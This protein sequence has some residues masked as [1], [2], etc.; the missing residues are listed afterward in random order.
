MKN[1]PKKESPEKIVF[2]TE[3]LEILDKYKWII[4]SLFTVAAF[5][6]SPAKEFIYHKIWAEAGVLAITA[7]SNS[8]RTQDEIKLYLTLLPN[9]PVGLSEG[10]ATV[11]LSNN[12]LRL[13]N[14]SKIFSTP[15]TLAPALLMD[16]KPLLL[17]AIEPGDAE[18]TV[19]VKT[20]L[21]YP[22]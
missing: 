13:V 16:G 3:T 1:K 21:D 22:Q 12:N 5:F 11:T 17:S 19:E 8:V 7:D 14:Q 15:K 20:L 2:F 10:I 6:L 4:G 18:I 9:S